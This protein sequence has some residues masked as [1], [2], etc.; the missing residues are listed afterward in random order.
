LFFSLLLI[1][2]QFHALVLIISSG[3]LVYRA[4]NWV[5]RYYQR[6]QYASTRF[7]FGML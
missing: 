2:L 3:L 1:K 6:C 5:W 7:G 4:G